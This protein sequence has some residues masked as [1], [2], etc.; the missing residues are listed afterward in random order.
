MTRGGLVLLAAALVGCAGDV[1]R[2]PVTERSV[3]SEPGARAPATAGTAD[4]RPTAYTVKRGDTLYAIA[5]DNG[6]DYRELAEW[7][8]L[9]DPNLILVG[10]ELVLTG[11][12]RPVRAVEPEV[13][14]VTAPGSVEAKPLPPL[15]RPNTANGTVREARPSES[16]PPPP[17][18]TT[19]QAPIAAAPARPPPPA[20]AEP[21]GD[22]IWPAAGQVVGQFSE[23]QKLKGIDIAA[24]VGDPVQAASAGRVVYT[25][26]ALR[27]YGRLVIIKHNDTYL[28]VY[29]HNSKILVKEGQQVSRGQR[30]AEAGDS[31]SD[32]P[33]LHFEIRR[34]GTPVDPL[35]LLP[36][37]PSS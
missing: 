1:R 16:R 30:I 31:D 25:G 20:N 37:T 10:Q 32:R 24:K 17:T 6:L 23:A 34:F 15:A 4:P 35:K 26:S 33:K 21:P 28:S 3:V 11:T 7:N 9:A 12:K 5:L 29:G 14:A 8:A 22:W 27:G 13:R 2:A 18:G 19:A 36:A